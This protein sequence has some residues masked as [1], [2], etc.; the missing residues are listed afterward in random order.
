MATS[1]TYHLIFSSFPPSSSLSLLLILHHRFSFNY[2]HQVAAFQINT[3]CYDFS[4]AINV[5]IHLICQKSQSTD[6]QL[7]STYYVL[8]PKDKAVKRA[9]M[10]PVFMELMNSIRVPHLNDQ[11]VACVARDTDLDFTVSHSVAELKS[12]NA[13]FYNQEADVHRPNV[14]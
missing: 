6:Q 13:S 8:G 5:N 14:H 10:F 11:Q 9:Y 2:Y 7:L 4:C 12:T 3:T 1:L